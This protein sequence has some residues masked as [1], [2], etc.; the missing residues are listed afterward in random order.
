MPVMITPRQFG[1]NAFA[2]L[3]IITLTDGL[4]PLTVSPSRIET[5]RGTAA[6]KLQV[7]AAGGDQHAIRLQRVPLLG[8]AHRQ[9]RER[10]QPRGQRS[11]ELRRHVLHDHHRRHR[12][13]NFRQ[14]PGQAPAARPSKFPRHAL[15]G[16]LRRAGVGAGLAGG[17]SRYPRR[18]AP[19]FRRAIMRRT[20]TSTA[21]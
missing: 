21:P 16:E 17:R 9:G 2:A 5:A 13:T 6:G 18:L 19:F 11:G 20:S 4:W 1:P 3:T 7:L 8:L 12:R 14:Q 15:V 10:I